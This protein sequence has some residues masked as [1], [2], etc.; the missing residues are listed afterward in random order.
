L[1]KSNNKDYDMKTARLDITKEILKNY[2]FFQ[3]KR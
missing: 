1:L 3:G 2:G